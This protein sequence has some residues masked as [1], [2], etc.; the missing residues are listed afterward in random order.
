M[1]AIEARIAAFATADRVRVYARLV[2]IVIG[3]GY[4]VAVAAGIATHGGFTDLSG[5]IV[6]ADYSAFY[7]AGHR[8]IE[9]RADLLYDVDAES[10]LTRA[11]VAPA[12][13]REEVH[14]FVSPPYWALA[15]V[16]LAAL[17]Y[18]ISLAVFSA[19]SI[20]MLFLS[21]R[22]LRD[23]FRSL[24][25]R[26]S[27]RTLARA[28]LGFFPVLLSLLNGQ[29]SMLLLACFTAFFAL[30][31]RQRELAAGLA[32]GLLAVKPP[33][34]LGPGLVALAAGRWRVLVGIACSASAWLAVGWSVMPDAMRAYAIA[35]PEIVELLRASEY[36]TWGQTSL[37]GL[38]TLL[39]D[40]I[41][42]GAATMVG[43]SLI[44]LA[45]IAIVVMVARTP[46]TPGSARWDLTLA[47][48][49]ALGFVASPHLFLYDTSLL[50]L[51]IAIAVARIEREDALLDG[52]PVL[53]ATF[54]VA[55]SVF[56]G[57][58]LSLGV[59]SA[60]RS[61]GAPPMTLQLCTLAIVWLAV[62]LYRRSRTEV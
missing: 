25:S 19:L 10:E 31:R 26:G 27:T 57:P 11:L 50:V 46:W 47:A 51:P 62:V 43:W 58:Y 7:G 22:M 3:G 18:P 56:V 23:A 38:A 55:V 5:A 12:P 9:G 13:W 29:T 33:L 8:V 2:T 36:H 53:A 15:F 48:A 35:T 24:A 49:L 30:L 37:F 42:H 39:L 59:Q 1:S 52:G 20:A 40:P 14:P 60:M 34:L 4:L 44:A 21:T 41:S 28:A 54:V 6:G 32:I 17:P 61:M 45:A 16:P